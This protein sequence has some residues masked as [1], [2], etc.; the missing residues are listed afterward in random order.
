MNIADR[1]VKHAVFLRL[2]SETDTA[3]NANDA[4]N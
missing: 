4:S 1:I 3:I 2:I